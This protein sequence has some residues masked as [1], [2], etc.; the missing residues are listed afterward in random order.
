MLL[1][2]SSLLAQTISFDGYTFLR[3]Q[4]KWYKVYQGSLFEVSTSSITIRL[5]NGVPARD[6]EPFH[7]A[8]N[9]ISWRE[10]SVGCTYL[11]LPAG[12]DAIDYVM[13][14]RG[15]RYVE[16]VEVST[17]GRFLGIP[18]DPQYGNQWY[19]QRIDMPRAWNI[20]TGKPYVIVGVLDSGTDWWHQ[21]D[22]RPTVTYNYQNIWLNPSE[23]TWA[24]PSDP[25]TGNHFDDDGNGTPEHSYVDDWKGWQYS[26]QPGEN[27]DSRGYSYV[28]HGTRVAGI[29]AA[30]T[31]N[32]AGIAGVAGG[33][34][35][36]GV[37][38]MI[39][40]FYQVEE[41]DFADAIGYAIAKGARN[42]QLS[43]DFPYSKTVALSLAA[44][45]SAGLLISCASGNSNGTV[46]FPA[47]YPVVVAV[48][49]TN[50]S[51]TRASFSNFGSALDLAAPG[52]DILTTTLNDGYESVAGTSYASPQVSALAALI[53]CVD[54]SL[55]NLQ[56]EDII[57]STAD[58]VGGYNYNWDPGRP[59]HS[60]EL[61]YGRIN[62]YRA[63]SKA[64]GPPSIRQISN[65]TIRIENG[66]AYPQLNWTL[67]PEVD[68]QDGGLI[69]IERRT[70]AVIDYSWSPWTLIASPNGNATQ[71]VDYDIRR[72][73][74]GNCPDSVQYRIRAQDY[75]GLYSPNYSAIVTI[76]AYGIWYKQP[77][78]VATAPIPFE[79]SVPYP[80]PFNPSTTLSFVIGHSSF[81]SLKVYDVLGREVAMLVNEVKPA[82][83]YTVHFDASNLSSGV[84]Y[85][86]LSVGSFTATRKMILTK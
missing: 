51:E 79:L 13:R 50:Q 22:M 38:M 70:K 32:S 43:L 16:W 65:I 20:Q 3:Q 84:Y 23:D 76:T 47:N 17:F 25:Q 5:R 37:R 21:W 74:V 73:C 12:A 68:V 15:N 55:T 81:A 41:Q 77:G 18:N 61:G 14:Y 45:H 62:A 10:N 28:A 46:A 72:M 80:N 19:L 6:I 63:I 4:G 67:A 69:A 52:T 30:K 56:V 54:P 42:I 26:P 49:A 40:G 44:A 33:W 60:Q 27:N 24:D 58:K 39:L 75:A 29:V 48:G 31:H 59:G 7:R 53:W 64:N 71:Y 36:P 1:F 83:T 11:S 8:N 86:R 2:T 82:G 66:N 35:D 85:Y 9:I 34:N 57:K 78:D